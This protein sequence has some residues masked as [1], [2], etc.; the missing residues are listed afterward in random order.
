[1]FKIIPPLNTDI[2]KKKCYFNDTS[3]RLIYIYRPLMCR[4]DGKCNGRCRVHQFQVNHA[5]QKYCL[6]INCTRT[7]CSKNHLLHWCGIPNN[8]DISNIT[9]REYAYSIY[10]MYGDD[11]IRQII[12]DNQSMSI[13]SSEYTLMK[14]LEHQIEITECYAFST[15][16][17]RYQQQMA[18]YLL[19]IKN[20][21]D[22]L[23]MQ[24]KY[25]KFIL[26][27]KMVRVYIGIR[28][29]GDVEG[30][31]K[32]FIKQQFYDF[33]IRDVFSIVENF[34]GTI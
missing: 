23:I 2:D 28:N 27:Q 18:D 16:D 1:M 9:P 31:Y 11:I 20:K 15:V 22:K 6:T 21:N 19:E 10:L 34:L 17:D 7:T 24:K 13:E 5:D 32:Q 29:A 3:G 26:G 33:H 25:K 30:D 14:A 4:F 12:F 8:I